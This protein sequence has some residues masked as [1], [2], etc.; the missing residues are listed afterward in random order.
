MLGHV[1]GGCAVAA[2]MAAT[3]LHFSS[4]ARAFTFALIWR[5]AMT[6]IVD[7]NLRGRKLALVRAAE[8]RGRVLD[9]GSGSGTQLAYLCGK[10]APEVRE[11][12]CVDP[13]PFFHAALGKSIERATDEAAAQG[14]D[15]RISLFPRTLA[16]YEATVGPAERASFDAITCFLVLCSVPDPDVAIAECLRFLKPGAGKLIYLEHVA[17]P[18]GSR[19]RQ[20]QTLLQPLNDL[21]GDGCQLCRETVASLDA[22]GLKRTHHLEFALLGAM[23]VVCGVCV[24]PV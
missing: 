23:P 21:I 3:T 6:K 7:R 5:S 4:T 13:N 11:I 19:W 8:L 12:V 16:E 17:A 15:V 9:V 14:I 10:A 2:A 1:L 22:A 20:V 24:K 18:A